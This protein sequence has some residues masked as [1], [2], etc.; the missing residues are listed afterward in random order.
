MDKFQ[1][2]NPPLRARIR[3]GDMVF[4][5]TILAAIILIVL[6]TLTYSKNEADSISVTANM[7]SFQPNPVEVQ[8]NTSGDF[9]GSSTSDLLAFFSP[10]SDDSSF[11]KDY[12]EGDVDVTYTWSVTS[13][14]YKSTWY[15]D[16]GTNV[17][18]YETATSG[19]TD[20]ITQPNPTVSFATLTFTP[21]IGAY[22]EVS[23]SCTVNITDTDTNQSWSGSATVGPKP[24]TS[25]DVKSIQVQET[26]PPPS[27]FETLPLT[28]NTNGA[29]K[30][31]A[32][33]S[34]TFGALSNPTYNPFDPYQ[35][36]PWPS[37][38]PTWSGSFG[39]S[40]SG[41]TTSASCSNAS[42]TDTDY[43]TITATC[44]NAV[45]QNALVCNWVIGLCAVPRGAGSSLLH[46]GHAW[47][48]LHN[49]VDGSSFSYGLYPS[50][51]KTPGYAWID[52]DVVFD[53]DSK[54]GGYANEYYL[55][56]PSQYQAFV[57]LI[58]SGTWSWTGFTACASFAT[59]VWSTATGQDVS[60]DF[61]SQV[62]DYVQQYESN[63][64]N[65]GATIPTAIGQD[66]PNA[67][68]W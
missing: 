14:Q 17:V 60:C 36:P 62:I 43:K 11:Y 55:L 68:N 18:P 61:P 67:V 1:K 9:T 38:E 28:F 49:L 35:N 46:Y 54:N 16:T 50:W 7:E 47:I 51:F 52:D 32:N 48:T 39:A 64:F 12:N 8:K 13:V 34:I 56:S 25:V 65:L 24:L 22:W 53:F 5:V 58:S 6:G 40:G 37:G 23:V 41:A 26:N 59:Q 33:Q 29:L 31:E 45:T 27:S 20:S 21:Q 57:N 2:T 42:A 63:N 10:P 3:F 66:A 15:D 19:F 4:F 44:G 30:V